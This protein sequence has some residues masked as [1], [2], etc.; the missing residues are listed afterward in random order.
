M[1]P[2][3]SRNAVRMERAGISNSRPSRRASAPRL[4]RAAGRPAGAATGAGAFTLLSV[5]VDTDES[6]TEHLRC[7]DGP[8]LPARAR[9]EETAPR[10]TPGPHRA[11]LLPGAPRS[12]GAGE[13]AITAWPAARWS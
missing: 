7:R 1:T 4:G 3:P 5:V 9:A 12:G 2:A 13:R 6:D 11:G 8:T 10:G